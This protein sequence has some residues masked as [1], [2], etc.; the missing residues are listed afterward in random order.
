MSTDSTDRTG[1][2]EPGTFLEA[3]REH[4]LA[5]LDESDPEEKDYHVRCALQACRI[6]DDD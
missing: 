6:P 5:A 1:T 2:V 3:A 4:L